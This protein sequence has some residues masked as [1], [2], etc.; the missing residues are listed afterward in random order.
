[1]CFTQAS[2]KNQLTQSFGAGDPATVWVLP[3]KQPQF[4]GPEPLPASRTP[5]VSS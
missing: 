4:L 3:C 5:L 2:G 1:M